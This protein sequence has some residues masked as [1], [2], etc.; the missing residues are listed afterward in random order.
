MSHI[1]EHIMLE[2]RRLVAE[3]MPIEQIAFYT[4]ID[5][6]IIEEE[7]KQ[8]DEALGT[9]PEEHLAMIRKLG[10]E[11]MSVGRIAVMTHMSESTVHE[12]L[13]IA[14]IEPTPNPTEEGSS[15]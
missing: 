2:V 1:P 14:G 12:V 7:L 9:I 6:D 10:H 15:R 5:P 11:R 4:R 8:R 3:R 13:A